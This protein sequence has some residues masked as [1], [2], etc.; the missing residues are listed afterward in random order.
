MGAWGVGPF[1]NDAAL[2]FA[3]GLADIPADTADGL[4][5]AMSFVVETDDYI[6]GPEM[7][8]ALAAACFVA[9]RMDP[10]VP[11]T[12]SGRKYLDELEFTVD[13]N[14][15]ALA[16]QVFV[17]A[18]EPADNE[19]YSLWSDSLPQVEAALAPY[20]AVIG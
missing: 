14:L 7:D 15:R 4:A 5:E 18:L 3:G 20:R 11:I 6:E 16:A 2:D 17:R 10:T 13:E 8:A 12:G 19:W 1:D 9:A